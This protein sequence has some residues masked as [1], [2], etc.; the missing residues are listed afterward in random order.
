MVPFQ[1]DSDRFFISVYQK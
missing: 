1:K